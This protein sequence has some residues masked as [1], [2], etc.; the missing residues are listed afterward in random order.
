MLKAHSLGWDSA[1]QGPIRSLG[2][3]EEVI[4]PLWAFRTYL[5]DE[6]NNNVSEKY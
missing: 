2:D 5:Q 4:S 1:C 6:T 3:L